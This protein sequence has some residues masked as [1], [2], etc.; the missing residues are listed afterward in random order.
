MSYGDGV[1]IRNGMRR[2]EGNGDEG[3]VDEENSLC[4]TSL[5]WIRHWGARYPGSQR[6]PIFERQSLSLLTY[7]NQKSLQL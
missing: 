1:L 5:I 2:M 6:R 7:P 4:G 3:G